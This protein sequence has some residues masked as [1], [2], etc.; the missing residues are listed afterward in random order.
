LP[1]LGKERTGAEL[2]E[3]LPELLEEELEEDPELRLLLD[4]EPEL[5][6]KVLA[7]LP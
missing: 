2:L 4:P 7:G 6:L 5:L 1:P 3:L